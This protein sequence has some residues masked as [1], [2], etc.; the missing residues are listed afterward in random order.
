MFLTGFPM[1]ISK[2][3][4]WKWET[5]K[6]NSA[7]LTTYKCYRGSIMVIGYPVHAVFGQLLGLNLWCISGLDWSGLDSLDL[8]GLDCTSLIM[9]IDKAGLPWSIP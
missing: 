8:Q 7:Q 1:T 4:A 6:I 9:P 5:E 3:S 2:N